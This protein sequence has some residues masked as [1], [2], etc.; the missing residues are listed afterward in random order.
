[1]E[2]GEPEKKE[3][4]RRPWGTCD[5]NVK[6]DLEKYYAVVSS[7]PAPGRIQWQAIMM[8][9]IINFPVPTF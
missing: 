5:D 9:I 3:P 2:I 1:M 4:V 8:V 7:E 6:M